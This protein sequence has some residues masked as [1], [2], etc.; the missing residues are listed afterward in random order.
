MT[1]KT[2]GNHSAEFLLSSEEGL[3]LDAGV[4]ITGQNLLAGTV[5]GKITASGKYTKHATG[6]ADGSQNAI[7]ILYDDTDA[8]SI[9]K[10]I[11]VVSR[12]AE[13]ID[14]KLIYMTS[15]SAPNKALAIA[16]LAVNQL[17]VRV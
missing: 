3:S 9:D 6:A 17:I 7:A 16:A 2:E 1:L 13:V 5:L 14:S 10:P 15:I 4:L 11:T 8:T 12:V